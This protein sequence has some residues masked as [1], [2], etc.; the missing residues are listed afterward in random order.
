MEAADIP[1]ALAL[2]ATEGWGYGAED[3]HRFM[4]MDPQGSLVAWADDERVGLATVTSY[5]VTAWIGNVIVQPEARAKGVGRALVEEALA[6]CEA[7][8]TESCWL[9]AYVHVVPFY[10]GLGFRSAGRTGRYQG[11]A[12]G[13]LRPEVR[14]AHAEEMAS[15]A[16]FDRPYFGVDRSKVLRAFYHDYGDA[17]YVWDEGEV[18][19]FVVGAAYEGGVDV[20]PLVARPERPDVARGL[21]E[22][23]LAVRVGAT[24]GLTVPHENGE[25]LR[26]LKDL[27]FRLRFETV[28]MVRGPPK[29]GIDPQGIFALA[30][31][32]KG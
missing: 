4:E 18:L 13:T 22:H 1:F 19:G 15:L 29:H 31:L 28:R 8:G 17:F 20:A 11:R 7:E 21:L 23:L 3:F 6:Y 5:G 30:G 25:G 12:T 26:T 24:V 14:L 27:G 2:T 16:A 10:E 32:E 9:N